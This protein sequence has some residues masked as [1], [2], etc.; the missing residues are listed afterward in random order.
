MFLFFNSLAHVGQT[1]FDFKLPLPAS[2]KPFIYSFR[3]CPSWASCLFF[4]FAFANNGQ[5]CF[6]SISYL[7]MVGR[8]VFMFILYFIFA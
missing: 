2:G 5:A 7:P 8:F 4:H 3:S 6:L 1:Y